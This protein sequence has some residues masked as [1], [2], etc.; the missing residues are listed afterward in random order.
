VKQAQG[1]EG[2]QAA[3][4]ALAPHIRQAVKAALQRPI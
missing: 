1:A 3:L 2:L 4:D